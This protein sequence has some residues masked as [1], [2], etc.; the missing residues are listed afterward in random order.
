MKDYIVGKYLMIIAIKQKNIHYLLLNEISYV[1]DI[2][3]IYFIHELGRAVELL[4]IT[5]RS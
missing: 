4:L 1:F 2:L 3:Y 5:F